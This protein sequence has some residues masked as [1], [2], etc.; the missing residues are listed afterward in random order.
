[1][2]QGQIIQ[3]VDGYQKIE[4]DLPFFCLLS[5][6]T[7]DCVLLKENKSH[8]CCILTVVLTPESSDKKPILACAWHFEWVAS[9]SFFQGG[10]FI[11]S[12][13]S[14]SDNDMSFGWVVIE[15]V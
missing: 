6:N 15:A 12:V 4:D 14:S 8:F 3:P 7:L 9:S 5:Y 13:V 10:S 2:W 1:M 11:P